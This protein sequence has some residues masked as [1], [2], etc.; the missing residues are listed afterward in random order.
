MRRVRPLTM[1][2][3]VLSSTASFSQCIFP[4]PASA[5]VLSYSFEP[6]VSEDRLTLRVTLEFSGGSTGKA[7]LELPSEWAGQQHAEK[8]VAELK[9]LS[10]E[11]TLT[12]TK[13]PSEKEMQFLPGTPVRISYVLVRDWDGPLNSDTRFRVDLSP[14]RFHMVGI[15]SLVHPDLDGH[16][17]V[18]VHFNWQKLPREWSLA[19]SFGT[20][21]R[22]QSFHGRWHEAINSLFVGGD[23]RIYRTAISG[24][25]LNFA[26]RGKWNFSDDEWVTQVRKITE[27]ERTFW[28]D[29]DFPYFLVTLTPLTQE[30]GSTGGTALTNAFMMHLSRLDSLETEIVGTIAHETFHTWSPYKM[31]YVPGSDYLTSWLWEGFT[32]YYADLMLFRAGL[33]SFPDYVAG[34]NEKLQK[35][36]LREGTEVTL[37]DFIRRHSADHSVLD[38]LDNRR[39]AVLA[40]WMDATIRKKTGNRASLDNLMFDLVRQNAAY[41]RRHEGK[42]MAITNKRIFHAAAQYLRRDSR[43]KLQQYVEQ[44]GSIPVPESALGPCAQ[45][46][47]E[48]NAKFDLG[49][50]RRSTR[51]Q[52]AV[53]FGVEPGSE[54]Y[55][56]GLRDGQRLLGWSFSFG[57]PSKE[58]WLSVATDSGNQ[59]LKYYP[60]GRAVS[61]QQFILDSA[62]YSKHPEYCSSGW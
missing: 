36:E 27:F 57:E 1:W 37:Q 2:L 8:A 26:I 7:K 54:A 25:A 39:G 51:N 21:D 34:I 13:S 46:H 62:R 53:A 5:N 60:R 30:H 6:I 22:C 48:P 61:V 40:A 12:D 18:D 31:G 4:A 19:T 35:Y 47:I 3:A 24:N 10:A 43:K 56:V 41:E 11:T 44:G 9:A 49:F 17:V 20:D 29:K 38:Q 14:D 50:D 45:S 59:M 42:L 58:V 32:A 28:H 52:P 15:T 23:Y 33:I 55:K 16:A